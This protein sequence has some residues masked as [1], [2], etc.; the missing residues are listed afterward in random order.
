MLVIS[1]VTLNIIYFFSFIFDHGRLLIDLAA[2]SFLYSLG[3]IFAFK[4]MNTFRQHIYPLVSNTRKCLTVCINVMWYGHRLANM[5]WVGIFLVFSG[6]MVEVVSNYSLVDKI[7]PN[8]NV[9]NYQGNQYDKIMPKDEDFNTG[10]GV[11]NFDG[12]EGI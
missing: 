8:R 5:Q 10:Y 1:V 7:M 2:Y 9:L 3:G 11:Q 4:L 6:I 12:V